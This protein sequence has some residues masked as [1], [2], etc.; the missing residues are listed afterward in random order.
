M[1]RLLILAE[2]ADKYAPLVRSAGLPQLEIVAASGQEEA[3]ALVAACN[4][5]LG[6]PPLVDAVLSSADRL[7]WVQ[8]SWAGVDR[9]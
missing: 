5:I 6:E 3:L 4:I 9:L 7:E 1:N 2:G 8:S